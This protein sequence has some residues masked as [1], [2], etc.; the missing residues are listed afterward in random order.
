MAK[1][2]SNNDYVGQARFF[3]S[4]HPT[5]TPRSSILLLFATITNS[6]VSIKQKTC[7]RKGY[8]DLSSQLCAWITFRNYSNPN[9]Q[10][11]YDGMNVIHW[12]DIIGHKNK[13]WDLFV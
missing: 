6:Q 4:A 12:H 13:V 5:L 2:C 1:M 7:A 8:F 11:T 10:L 3:A 9:G